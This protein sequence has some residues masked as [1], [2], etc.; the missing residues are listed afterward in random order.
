MSATVHLTAALGALAVL[1]L[2][3]RAAVAEPPTDA[4]RYRLKVGQELTYRQAGE[5]KYGTG[6]NAGVLSNKSDW[7]VWVVRANPDGGWRLVLRCG[8]SHSQ[9]FGKGQKHEGQPDNSLAYCDLGPDGRFAFNDSLGFRLNPSAVFPQLPAAAAAAKRGWEEVNARDGS[10]THF[11]A[12]GAPAADR[13]VFEGVDESPMDK[14]Y[15]STSKSKYTF[16]PKQGLLAT[17]ESENTQG[18][19]FDGK[20]TGTTELTGVKERDADFIK[21]LAAEAETYFAAEKRYQDLCTEAGKNPAQVKDLLAKAEAALKEAQGKVK[22]EV[23]R[24]QIAAKLKGH[25]Q[26]ARWTSDDAERRA[27]VV[28]KPAADWKTTDLDGKPV[29]LEGLRGKVVVMDFWYRGCGWCVR[30]MPQMKQLADDFRDQ[31]VVILGMNT[32][33]DE[34]DAR[35]VVEQMGLNYPQLKAEGLPQKYGVQGFPTLI[36]IDQSGKVHDIH[37]GY[38]PTLR[39][40]VGKEIRELLSRK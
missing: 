30:A 31:P 25:E 20:G 37:V 34:K 13:F 21:Q 24:E 4:P 32:D 17:A 14:I 28:G 9:T 5:F 2:G 10:Q 27:K 16:D 39:Q 3:P 1:A 23:V 7:T 8:Q 26:T 36:V 11:K 29:S 22:L 33:R 19:G 40:D 35:F 15:L 6:E 18:Y 38:T 12:A